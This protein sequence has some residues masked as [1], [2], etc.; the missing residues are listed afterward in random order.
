MRDAKR[1]AVADSGPIVRVTSNDAL[2][3]VSAFK[4]PRTVRRDRPA[5]SV[6]S[7]SA[8]VG[9]NPVPTDKRLIQ[10]PERNRAEIR[11]LMNVPY[12]L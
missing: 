12:A 3:P 4:G 11:G 7:V 9:K 2:S 10:P 8:E 6:S 5:A 1:V